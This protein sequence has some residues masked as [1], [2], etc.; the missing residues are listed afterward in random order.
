MNFNKL[1]PSF[2][3]GE[4]SPEMYSRIDLNKYSI[5][6]KEASNMFI[7]KGG[8]IFN[9]FGTKYI[10]EVKDSTKETYLKPF[11]Y[12]STDKILIESGESYFRYYKDDSII[13]GGSP[14]ETVTPYI[15]DDLEKLK[16]ERVGNTIYIVNSEY[17]V[18]KLIRT[19]D[20]SWALSTVSFT[21]TITAPTGVAVAATGSTA[22]T[23]AWKY[24]ITTVNDDN[25]EEESLVSSVVSATNN[26]ELDYAKYNTITWNTVTGAK[27]YYIY[28]EVGGVYAWIGETTT[29]SF[30]DTGYKYY[31]DDN[32]PENVNPFSGANN[33][34]SVVAMLNE[35]IIY[36]STNNIPNAIYASRVGLYDNF[37]IG[38]T[39]QY[40]D[41]LIFTL[42]NDDAARKVNNILTLNSLI[43]MTEGSIKRNDSNP[44]TPTNLSLFTESYDGSSDLDLAKVGNNVVYVQN[45]NK[46]VRNY[47]YS[48]D[49]NSF[50]GDDLTTFASH[51]FKDV[52][53][54]KIAFQRRPNNI[55]WC[56][57]SD[58]T[59]RTLT[60]VYEQQIIA[61][62]RQET[63][64][65]FE[66]VVV[67]GGDLKDEVY[68]I[69]QRNGK[70]L[71][72][73]YQQDFIENTDI[74]DSWYLDSAVKFE[75]TVTSTTLTPSVI[76]GIDIT[77]TAGASIFVAGDVGR[78]FWSGTSKAR[79]TTYVSGTDVICKIL[80]DFTST[81]AIA[82]GD[83][84]FTTK[85]I[86][87]L[88]HI[89]GLTVNVLN[90]GNV[91]EGHVVTSGE[92]TLYNTTTKCVV[93]LP[94]ESKLT[95]LDVSIL[96]QSSS[97][98]KPKRLSS[99][100]LLLENT[101][102]MKIGTSDD[103]LV[104]IKQRRFE[105][106]GGPTLP[107]NGWFKQTVKSNYDTQTNIIIKQ[108]YPLPIT[109]NSIV[110]DLT[111]GSAK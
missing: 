99:V 74:E 108:V 10:G 85:V 19:S 22:V 33:Y 72:E 110:Y 43:I 62:T 89:E 28:Q 83:W 82:A 94:Y 78:E 79:I 40:N 60:F 38:T 102:G 68:F 84:E 75:S 100:K 42:A 48:N 81:S 98:G 32:P 63:E 17:A 47:V 12:S 64:G 18:R 80:K 3:G 97:Q 103:N 111:L 46:S 61:W 41:A 50:T 1:Q 91:E 5:S 4:L 105:N 70:R 49:L 15:E 45:G 20:I 35:R 65:L 37:S 36:A 86:D 9:R 101:R 24:V 76:T 53:I 52:T 7:R 51:I 77:F 56:V 31:I 96:T 106:W 13:G 39:T 93:G 66:D 67:L 58:G 104:E 44:L 26:V 92:I 11:I 8:G 87:G 2:A 109:I 71:I 23:R 21:P 69:V 29:L 54:K 57:C 88:D 90:N 6:F 25:I 14:V 27:K 73:K 30:I 95:G 55:L 59:I 34:P 16:T 107:L